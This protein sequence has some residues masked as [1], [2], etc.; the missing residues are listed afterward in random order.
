MI[1]RKV[2]ITWVGIERNH[3]ILISVMDVVVVSLLVV[4]LFVVSEE[5]FL[6]I[7]THKVDF[8]RGRR[9]TWRN[10]T[11]KTPPIATF[12]KRK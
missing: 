10:E 6:F 9:E 2:S 5:V 4:S 3:E 8:H 11:T 1:D 7:H 12:N